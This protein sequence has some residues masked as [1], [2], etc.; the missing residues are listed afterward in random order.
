MEYEEV[1]NNQK[2]ESIQRTDSYFDG[3]FIEYIGYK[4]LAFIITIATFT[5]AKPWADVLVMEYVFN[6]TV[7]NGKRLKFEGKGTD[8]FI[9]RFKWILFTIIT[10]GIYSLWIPLNQEKWTVSNIHFEDEEL[11]KEDSYFDGKL[12]ELIGLN[13]FMYLLNLLTLGLLIPFTICYKYKW[14]T[15]HTIINRKRIVFTGN[16]LSLF[17]NYLLWYLLS[18]VTIGIYGLWLPM[19]L[20]G[21]KIK[22]THIKLKDEKEEKTSK[23]PLILG[24]IILI[25]VIA[26]FLPVINKIDLSNSGNIFDTIKNEFEDDNKTIDNIDN[27]YTTDISCISEETYNKLTSAVSEKYS[28]YV[29]ECL[30]KNKFNIMLVTSN[31]EE[32]VTM[33]QDNVSNI[34]GNLTKEE[35]NKLDI[36]ISY[37]KVSTNSDFYLYGEKNNDVINWKQDGTEIGT[38]NIRNNVIDN[39]SNNTIDNNQTNLEYCPSCSIYSEGYC[40][41]VNSYVNAGSCGYYE[42]INGRCYPAGCDS[43]NYE[44]DEYCIND[45]LLKPDSNSCPEG[46]QFING[47]CYNYIVK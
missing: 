24:P 12:L 19:K 28:T 40:Y 33:A 25:L 2:K 7:Y 18:I 32:T 5:I 37:E 21:W 47:L 11:N 15:N 43:A 6:H 20:Y 36:S 42:E 3:K 1:K 29:L 31:E 10:L 46:F 39:N 22:N 13:L 44:T 17:G 35:I 41:D 27:E 45:S 30:N 16:G 9:Q 14:I 23:I 34:L 4:L 8:L 26:V 38:S